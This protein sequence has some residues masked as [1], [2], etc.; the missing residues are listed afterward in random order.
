M[1]RPPRK[2]HLASSSCYVVSSPLAHSV[3]SV[4][5][6]SA[7]LYAQRV[8]AACCTRSAPCFAFTA[9]QRRDAPVALPAPP[10]CALRCPKA[11]TESRKRFYQQQARPSLRTC[12]VD[13]TLGRVRALTYRSQV[14]SLCL[15][16]L[17]PLPTASWTP[18]VK[19]RFSA[20]AAALCARR[21]VNHM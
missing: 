9:R 14:R 7:R 18:V 13:P 4:C 19:C 16:S 5:S 8:Q 20:S 6:C 1:K 17:K 10:V 12:N 2:F 3:P 15:C 21:R 11:H